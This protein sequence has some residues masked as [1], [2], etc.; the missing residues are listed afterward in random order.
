VG[1]HNNVWDA[2]AM[3]ETLAYR[4]WREADNPAPR[5]GYA[6]VSINGEL[7]GLYTIVQVMD[8]E[9][10]ADWWEGPHGALYEMTRG[11]DWTSDCS[12]WELEYAGAG[13]DP[14]AVKAGCDAAA[15]A[16]DDA[17]AL[18]FD[19][20]RMVRYLALERVLNHPDSYSF[21][22][23]NFHVY[24]DPVAAKITLTPWGADST[25]TYVYP[26]WDLSQPCEPVYLDVDYTT[27]YGWLARFCEDDPTCRDGMLDSMLQLAD[28][29]EAIDLAGLASST[30]ERIAPYIAEDP[31]IAYSAADND[32]QAA[33]FVDWIGR[34]PDEVRAWVSG[35][36]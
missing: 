7:R 22:L 15:R 36:R 35:N 2:S 30:H 23:N 20:D 18:A 1:L 11:C 21:N 29:L 19:W 6:Q 33:C 9:F 17:I 25:F 26:P 12:C 24:V 14:E 3:A 10:A 34:R 28:L 16:D 27:P 5:T 31:K 32:Y 13:Y 4:T 8:G